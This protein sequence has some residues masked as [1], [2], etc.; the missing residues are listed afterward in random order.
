MKSCSFIA[1][2]KIRGKAR[3]RFNTK[4]GRAYSSKNDRI[5]ENIIREAHRAS[6]GLRFDDNDY[7][8]AE[9]D[10]YFA[11]PKSYSKKRRQNCLLG[12]EKPAKKP[13]IDN[14]LK[15]I[16]DSLNDYCYKDDIQ[17]VEVICRKYYTEEQEDY[18]SVKMEEIK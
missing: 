15:N 9:I 8:R 7:I 12:L 6:G 10:L 4:T 5:Y 14:V 2:G 3:P 18:I 17:I 11:I 1:Y 13:D 16:F